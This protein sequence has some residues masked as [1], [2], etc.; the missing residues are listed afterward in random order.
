MFLRFVVLKDTIE[1]ETEYASQKFKKCENHEDALAHGFH[2]KLYLERE[3]WKTKITT[4]EMQMQNE[5]HRNAE[6]RTELCLTIEVKIRN[7]ILLNLLL[8]G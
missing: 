7:N 2:K 8:N 3:Q 6:K 4:L 5:S 1:T